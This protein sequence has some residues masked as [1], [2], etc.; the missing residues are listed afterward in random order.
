MLA[1]VEQVHDLGG[2][3]ELGGGD[4]PDPGGAVA[5]DGE[6]ADVVGAAADPL[7]FHQVPERGGGL[8][9]GDDAGGV[10]VADRVAVLVQPVLGEED[11]ELDLA[12]AGAA[13]L[14]LPLPAR[15]LP[16]GHGHPGAVDDRIQLVRQRRRGQGDQLPGGDQRGPAA[17]GRRDG[18]AAGLGRPLGALDGEP[19]ACQFLQQGGCLRERDRGGGAVVHRGQARRHGR[20]RRAELGVPRREAVPAL[21]A[22]IPGPRQGD[23]A[24]HRVDG[25][26]PVGDE[27]GLVPPAARDA[28]SPVPAVGGQQLLQHA[29]AKPQQPGPEHRLRRLQPGITAA[30]DPGRLGGQPS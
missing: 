1:G 15:S 9:G 16:G 12:G 19:D 29:P 23:R 18:A 5:D 17:G 2:L 30:Q 27:H 7:R 28:R 20:A 21:G 10:P 24:E 6:L 26:V 3:R 8:E 11:G 25:L 4:A 14:A 13:V 22:V